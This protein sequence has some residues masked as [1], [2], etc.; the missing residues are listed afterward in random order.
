MSTPLILGNP[1]LFLQMTDSI[2]DDP[3]LTDK[4]LYE[5]ATA[6][7]DVLDD[8]SF[9][10]YNKPAGVP[11]FDQQNSDFSVKRLIEA[12]YQTAQ[13]LDL[14][15]GSRY[16]LASV[17]ACGRLVDTAADGTLPMTTGVSTSEL[18]ASELS[19]MAHKLWFTPM[20]QTL[21][22]PNHG[23]WPVYVREQVCWAAWVLK[24]D[25]YACFK[26][27]PVDVQ[28]PPPPFPSDA[29]TGI[30]REL[31]RVTAIIQCD[32]PKRSRVRGHWDVLL[33]SNEP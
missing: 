4:E 32:L 30:R 19:T 1:R 23:Q 16:I 24:R 14:P 31:L 17:C 9:Q 10:I 28:A 15:R 2:V 12:F 18:L 8:P 7:L 3:S 25:S 29:G 27:G 20:S 26:T 5:R 13:D 11:A 6:Y 22:P 33:Q 21:L